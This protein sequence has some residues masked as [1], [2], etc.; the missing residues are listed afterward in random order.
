MQRAIARVMHPRGQSRHQVQ[1]AGPVGS[2]GRAL[3][4][5][6]N[7]QI[8]TASTGPTRAHCASVRHKSHHHTTQTPRP[9]PGQQGHQCTIS[10]SGSTPVRDAGTDAPN[11]RDHPRHQASSAKTAGQ[12]P[13]LNEQGTA[14]R[15]GRSLTVICSQGAESRSAS[16]YSLPAPFAPP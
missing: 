2:S 11:S 15:A 4:S 13:A 9:W 1:P 7:R 12:P 14:D 6:R 5:A 8:P 3:C 16:A 10:P